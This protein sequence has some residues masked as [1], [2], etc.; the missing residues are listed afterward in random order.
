[1]PDL[2]D[3]EKR[4]GLQLALDVSG[5]DAS[6]APFAEDTRSVNISGGGLCF[7]SRHNLGVGSRVTVRIELPPGLRRHFGNKPVY[8]ARAVVCR[9]ERFE[10]QAV[11]R[12]GARFLGEVEA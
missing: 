6:G 9:V 3:R 10:G 7:E 2:S 4:V 8:R 12:I 1:M 5:L 11:A